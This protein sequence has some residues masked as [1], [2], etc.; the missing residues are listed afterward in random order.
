MASMKNTIVLGCFIL[1]GFAMH[2]YLHRYEAVLD[3]GIPW[4]YTRFNKI[5][6]QFEVYVTTGRWNEITIGN[7]TN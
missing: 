6:A 4:K 2:A 3:D 7:P 1:A 5:T